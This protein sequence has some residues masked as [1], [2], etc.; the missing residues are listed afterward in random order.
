MFIFE[1]LAS[2]IETYTNDIFFSLLQINDRS[3]LLGSIKEME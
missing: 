2:V 1:E 3:L